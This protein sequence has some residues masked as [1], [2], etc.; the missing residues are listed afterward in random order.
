ME[1]EMETDT[2]NSGIVSNVDQLA[3]PNSEKEDSDI[4]PI[5]D[6]SA[7]LDTKKDGVRVRHMAESQKEQKD[8]IIAQFVDGTIEG[9]ISTIFVT[10]TDD[11]RDSEEILIPTFAKSSPTKFSS[12]LPKGRSKTNL[13]KGKRPR[14]LNTLA[15]IDGDMLADME[16][17]RLTYQKLM[18]ELSQTSQQIEKMERT[19]NT[20]VLRLEEMH[21]KRLIKLSE[22]VTYFLSE[23]IPISLPVPVSLSQNVLSAI[24]KIDD[25]SSFIKTLS[26]SRELQDVMRK[27]ILD[28]KML[29]VCSCG[30]IYVHPSLCFAKHPSDQTLVA[31]RLSGSAKVSVFKRSGVLEQLNALRYFLE[32]LYEYHQTT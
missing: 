21:D 11:I 30:Y 3:N 13:S 15:E 26:E 2:E 32:L 16:T 20:L 23:Y 31:G 8:R 24:L 1:V 22:C 14:I 29:P 12:I 28:S 17:G 10:P 9:T 5:E 27:T 4:V 18:Y 6:Q 25:D 7:N 19:R